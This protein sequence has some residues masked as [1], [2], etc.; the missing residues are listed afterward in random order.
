MGLGFRVFGSEARSER[1]TIVSAFKILNLNTGL[2]PTMVKLTTQSLTPKPDALTSNP[3]PQTLNP[4][5]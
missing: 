4:K 2:V 1:G 5:S 3:K